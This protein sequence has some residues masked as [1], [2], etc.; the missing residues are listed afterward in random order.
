M[1][2]MESVVHFEMPAKDNA[3]A[4]KFY[5]TVFGW[6][7]QQLGKEMGEYVLA[8]TAESDKNGPKTPGRINGGF[9]PAKKDNPLQHPSLVIAV[10]DLNSAI[11]KIEKEGGKVLGKPMDIPNIGCYVSFEDTEGNRNSIIQPPKEM[12]RE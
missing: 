12:W 9:F 10:K 1:N 11:K 7:M 2:S 6:K 3:R 5:S 4:T 8:M